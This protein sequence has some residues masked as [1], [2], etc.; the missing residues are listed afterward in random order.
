MPTWKTDEGTV[1]VRGFRDLPISSQMRT[2]RSEASY[3]TIS[4]HV[5]VLPCARI[6]LAEKQDL[7]MVLC[8]RRK[9]EVTR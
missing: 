6:H 5:P 9:P 4:Y 8:H 2:Q 3:T 7:C 1:N